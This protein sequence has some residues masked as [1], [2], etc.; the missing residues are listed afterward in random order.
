MTKSKYIKYSLIVAMLMTGCTNDTKKTDDNK[1][2]PHTQQQTEINFTTS[3]SI[4]IKEGS[5]KVEQVKTDNPNVSFSIVGGDDKDKFEINAQD[6]TLMFKT[7]PD[8]EHP[9]DKNGDN[10]YLVTIKAHDSNAKTARQN[11]TIT[12]LDD[13]ADNGPIFTS[14][15]SKK[16]VENTLLDFTVNASNAISY[17]IAGGEDK[18]RFTIDSASG[19]L[20]FLNFIPDYEHSSDANHDNIYKI[21]VKATDTAKNSSFQEISIIIEDDPD[22]TPAQNQQRY[23]FK[24]GADDGI[25]TGNP[26]GD[27]RNFNEETIGSDRKIT[28]GNRIWEDSPHTKQKVTYDEA[29]RYCNQ[30]DYAGIDNWRVPKRHELFEIINYGKNPAIDDIF[31]NITDGNYWTSQPIIN[32]K[33]ETID[34]RAFVISFTYAEPFPEKMDNKSFVR[35][36]SGLEYED[37]TPLTKNDKGIYEDSTTGLE[38]TKAADNQSWADA[39]KRCEDLNVS[40]KSDWRLPNISELHSIMPIYN[41]EFLLDNDGDGYG[42]LRG[43]FWSSTN[44]T[45]NAKARFIANYWDPDTWATED[46]NLS[47]QHPVYGRDVLNDDTE[48]KTN[49]DTSGSICVRGGH[50]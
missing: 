49:A 1:T 42:D 15:N 27:D 39:K 38:W 10:I 32:Y 44:A 22:D 26:F 29:L 16:L 41:E 30:L 14:S 6:G 34:N 37:I 12:V 2:N 13:K 5:L 45:N 40:G 8:F 21:R 17:S 36:V 50:L 7:K 20:N 24:T 9:V 4:N 48:T 19:K 25:T 35:C 31:T 3:G 43:P 23:I 33:G 18:N 28:V 11:L 47:Q 46:E